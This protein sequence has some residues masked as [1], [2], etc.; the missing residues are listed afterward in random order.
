[1]STVAPPLTETQNEFALGHQGDH[2][3]SMEAVQQHLQAEQLDGGEGGG[4]LDA[5]VETQAGRVGRTVETR[6]SCRGKEADG[7]VISFI[8]PS[9]IQVKRSRG[10]ES[11]L[12]RLKM[13]NL[14]A[15]ISAQYLLHC[16]DTSCHANRQI[17]CTIK[18]LERSTRV[19]S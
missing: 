12:K 6:G 10:E 19:F 18:Y 16:Y 1:M 17:H 3:W 2:F 15:V 5:G 4:R 13:P 14:S 9:G 7:P 11:H 8:L